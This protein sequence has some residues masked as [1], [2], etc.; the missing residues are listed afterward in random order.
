MNGLLHMKRAILKRLLPGLALGAILSLAL[1]AAELVPFTD[2][3]TEQAA[4]LI[5]EKEADSLFKIIDVRSA[6]EFAENRIKDA[7]N[8]DIKAADFREKIEK[9]DR[10]GIYLMFCLGGVRSAR[11]MNLMKEW[12]FKQAY[13][14]AGGLMKWQAQ[15]LPLESAP[16][17]AAAPSS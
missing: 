7:L 1:P 8:I 16:V 12:G 6:A 10:N 2:I 4:A 14:L 11:A 13:N 3:T 9:L 5:R 15:K 17:Q